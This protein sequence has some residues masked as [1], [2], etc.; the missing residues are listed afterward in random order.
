MIAIPIVPGKTY[1]V[2]GSGLDM[3][4][5]VPGPCAALCA[6]IDVLIAL[7]GDA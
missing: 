5:Q 7:R 4:V 6:A 3:I 1:R 2:H